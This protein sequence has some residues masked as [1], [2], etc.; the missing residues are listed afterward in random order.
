MISTPRLAPAASADTYA[1]GVAITR[2]QGHAITSSTSARYSHI[3]RAAPPG[4]RR[5]DRHENREA[6]DRRRIDP[7]EPIDEG[8]CRSALG[9]RRLDQM[10]HAP[11]RRVTPDPHGTDVE[12]PVAVDRAR[13]HLVTE[14]FVHRQRFTGNRRLID[15]ASSRN[16]LAVERDLFARPDADDLADLDSLERDPRLEAAANHDGFGWRQVHQRADCLPRAVHAVRFEVL[17][18]VEQEDDR[19]RLRPLADDECPQHRDRHQHVHVER[20]QTHCAQGPSRRV[21]AA[22]RD[23]DCRGDPRGN[24]P[25]ERAGR[26]SDGERYA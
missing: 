10:N 22:C 16:D 1:T 8:L 20:V 9:L 18:Q 7:G 19:G 24:R 11:Q 2:A 12:R 23:R 3:A 5:H 21:D 6:D 26:Q 25:V 17:R 15:V 4:Q 13:E 14:P